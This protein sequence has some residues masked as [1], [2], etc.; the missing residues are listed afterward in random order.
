[1]HHGRRA[2][3]AALPRLEGICGASVD[4]A[5]HRVGQLREQLLERQR[6]RADLLHLVEDAEEPVDPS[7][8]GLQ[9]SQ[10]GLDRHL[11]RHGAVVG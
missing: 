10:P 8:D 4:R 9:G 5:A 6:F 3:A 7:D 1:M 11:L 2:A